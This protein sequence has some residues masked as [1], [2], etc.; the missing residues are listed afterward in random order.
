ME[1][2]SASVITITMGQSASA[3][4]ISAINAVETFTLTSNGVGY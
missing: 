4:T 2:I 1:D 3:L